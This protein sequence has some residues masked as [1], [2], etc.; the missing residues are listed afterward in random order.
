MLKRNKSI[1]KAGSYLYFKKIPIKSK[2]KKE[3]NSVL[4]TQAPPL[5]WPH[6]PSPPTHQTWCL[7]W[8]ALPLLVFRAPEFSLRPYSSD[9][10][11]SVQLVIPFVSVLL[12]SQGYRTSK[13]E[14]KVSKHLINHKLYVTCKIKYE[15]AFNM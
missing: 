9:S 13:G 8:V 4:R 7:T 14:L 12:S 3:R 1:S 15:V 6:S 10:L 2:R 11:C 5:P